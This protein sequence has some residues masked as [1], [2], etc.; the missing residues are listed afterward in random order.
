[1]CVRC[2]INA[3]TSWWPKNIQPRVHEVA[4]HDYNMLP[5]EHRSVAMGAGTM[6]IV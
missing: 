6:H 1:M 3:T 4:R 5:V 2:P